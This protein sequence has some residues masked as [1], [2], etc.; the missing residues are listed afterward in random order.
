[1][2][3]ENPVKNRGTFAPGAREKRPHSPS[4]LLVNAAGVV[5]PWPMTC[6]GRLVGILTMAVAPMS[7]GVAQNG[8]MTLLPDSGADSSVED[9]NAATEDSFDTAA[10]P[11]GSATVDADAADD[12]DTPSEQD[13]GPDENSPGDGSPPEGSLIDRP[14]GPCLGAGTG[15][16]QL[17][18]IATGIAHACA[19]LHSGGVRCWG[20]NDRGQ[21]G[22][23]TQGMSRTQPVDVPG[24]EG[25]RQ[26]AA[27]NHTCPL[28]QAGDVMCWGRNDESQLGDGGVAS[29]TS[30]KKVD[31]LGVVVE[32]AVGTRHT[33]VVLSGGT[34]SC[35]GSNQLGQ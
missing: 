4:A 15:C 18:S 6:R 3:V 8:A 17:T 2:I 26:V 22:V 1:M 5:Y 32:I 27:P 13:A 33:C 10:Q 24:V 12:G 21:L 34:V 23:D 31:G 29:R 11:D 28:T 35:W 7:C 25:V 20:A 19:V 14:P 30:P 9:G 16:D